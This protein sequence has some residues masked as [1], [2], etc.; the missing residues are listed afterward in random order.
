MVV[1]VASISGASSKSKLSYLQETVSSGRMSP[2]SLLED[3]DQ[4]E[5]DDGN[6]SINSSNSNLFKIL[7][8]EPKSDV[9]EDVEN[10]KPTDD[11]PSPAKDL[12][13][14]PEPVNVSMPPIVIDQDEILQAARK[15]KK[16]KNG[17]SKK[18]K[19]QPPCHITITIEDVDKEKSE[20]TIQPIFD[21]IPEELGDSK[22]VH[23]EGKSNPGCMDNF[24]SRKQAPPSNAEDL[25][26]RN[27]QELQE[28]LPGR[29]IAEESV[30]LVDNSN[31]ETEIS[32]TEVHRVTEETETAD[33]IEERITS[34]YETKNSNEEEGAP[35]SARVETEI[36][37]SP[38]EGSILGDDDGDDGA[39]AERE[40]PEN[41]ESSTRKQSDE[42]NPLAE[43]GDLTTEF[44]ELNRNKDVE[45]APPQD[46][47][48]DQ[49]MMQ[50]KVVI[51]VEDNQDTKSIE[52]CY[53]VDK[54]GKM[55]ST[56]FNQISSGGEMSE[57][58]AEVKEPL[59]NQEE[60]S[61]GTEE[62]ELHWLS[63]DEDEEDEKS[64]KEIDFDTTSIADFGGEM[65]EV[66]ENF[67]EM[68]PPDWT[69]NKEYM[70]SAENTS[71]TSQ[72]KLD[73]NWV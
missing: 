42:E 46:E 28:I 52:E 29:Y 67:I 43:K 35:E 14:L 56:E 19:T 26:K 50:T 12:L 15:K 40:V 11:Y 7:L 24:K 34:T 72:P 37:S 17:K 55:E 58:L 3:T 69:Q 31:K 2:K 36:K 51:D 4:E 41:I 5:Y 71:N 63:T 10:G 68:F 13:S 45:S 32:T 53:S 70:S 20:G 1:N 22:S 21:G 59:I 49:D 47:A 6:N 23:V 39:S 44:I 64:E 57:S 60:S 18:S 62:S 27:D 38:K 54:H 65:V 66:G 73:L 30:P 61:S 48:L 16:K 9:E 33:K 8:E 25:N